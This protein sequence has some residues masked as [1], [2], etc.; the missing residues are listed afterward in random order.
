MQPLGST[1]SGKTSSLVTTNFCSSYFLLH[2]VYNLLVHTDSFL[3]TC[4][5]NVVTINVGEPNPLPHGRHARVSDTRA[6]M[7][8]VAALF[9]CDPLLLVWFV[10]VLNKI[11]C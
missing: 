4:S 7:S 6:I 9:S 10:A 1:H 11:C 5:F 8:E 3:L 2:P